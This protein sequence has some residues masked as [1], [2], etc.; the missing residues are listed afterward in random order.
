MAGIAAVFAID[1]CLAMEP[2]RELKQDRCEDSVLLRKITDLEGISG[3]KG[4]EDLMGVP[5]EQAIILR[6]RLKPEIH[7][8]TSEPAQAAP[9][10]Y[11]EFVLEEVMIRF[12]LVRHCS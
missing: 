4:K 5:F 8:T 11:R 3:T 7:R 2:V 9:E 12:P 10:D 6:G 1:V